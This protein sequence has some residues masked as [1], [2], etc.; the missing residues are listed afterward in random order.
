MKTHSHRLRQAAIL[1]ALTLT[2]VFTP[3]ASADS[4]RGEKTLG[5]MGGYATYNH[6]GFANVY[7]QYSFSRHVRIAPEVGIV[8]SNDDRSA[9]TISGDVHFP[10]R[11]VSGFQVYP[12]VGLTFNTWNYTH[13]N[14]RLRIG[15]DFGVGFD[16]YM[17]QHLKINLQG[18]YS[19]MNDTSGAYF[20]LGIGYVF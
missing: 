14:T 9:L 13:D 12:L 20:G 6:S 8:F 4:V 10:F 16:L 2:S 17:T 18:K 19:L 7:F 5:L 3:K 11:I 15:G 1:A